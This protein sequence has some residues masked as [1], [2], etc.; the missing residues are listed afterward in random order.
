MCII[1]N[2]EVQSSVQH[3]PYTQAAP[4]PAAGGIFWEVPWFKGSVYKMQLLC[5]VTEGSQLPQTQ[6]I[7]RVWPLQRGC[8]APSELL[9]PS[10]CTL[11]R[12]NWI[13]VHSKLPAVVWNSKPHCS[14]GS[15]QN[16]LAW[17]MVRELHQ[18]NQRQ[19]S[20]QELQK[21]LQ[22]KAGVCLMP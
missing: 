9:L 1:L 10:R 16:L 6:R 14:L 19:R 20:T 21:G 17:R 8:T 3:P 5:P 4:I 22:F 18:W 15:P 2:K 11:L 7:S 13:L 12:R